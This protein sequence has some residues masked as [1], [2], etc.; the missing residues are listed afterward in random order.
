M[1]STLIKD[2]ANAVGAIAPSIATALL[3]PAGGITVNLLE[4]L[5]GVKSAD[6]PTAISSDPD[7]KVKLQALADQHGEVLARL[8]ETDEENARERDVE[9]IK[10]GKSD[11][12]L[13]FL[14]IVTTI[15]FFTLCIIN[16][17]FDLKDDHI[18]IMMIGQISSGFVM[19]LSYYFGSSQVQNKQ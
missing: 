13:S 19:V 9:I 6:L 12:V 2:I 18:L 17:F 4:N 15:G 11:W 8:N 5:F 3:G 14:A 1:T 16:Y 7:A 10:A